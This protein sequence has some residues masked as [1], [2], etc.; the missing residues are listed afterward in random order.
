VRLRLL[1]IVKGTSLRERVRVLFW[2]LTLITHF[3]VEVRLVEFV[4]FWGSRHVDVTHKLCDLVR[5]G[6]VQRNGAD[7]GGFGSHDV[8]SQVQR[9]VEEVVV[10]VHGQQ[11]GGLVHQMFLS[12]LVLLFYLFYVEG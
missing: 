12:L 2:H 5:V 8:V 4:T 11:E 7:V 1:H 3:E 10:V 6:M 9:L